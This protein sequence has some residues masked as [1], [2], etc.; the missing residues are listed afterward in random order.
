MFWDKISSL[1]DLF[2]NVY[3]HKV[4][5]GTGKKVAELIDSS[6]DVLECACGT[7]A[8]TI[9]IYDK[10]RSLVATDFSEKMLAQAI[11]KYEKARQRPIDNQGYAYTKNLEFVAEAVSW[12]YIQ[13]VINDSSYQNSYFPDDLKQTIEKYICIAKN[14][15]QSNGC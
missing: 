12:Y 2:E 10:C 5:T 15:Y 1:Y 3:N 6:D 7:G 14:A 11:K 13:F 8:I 4:F 9:E